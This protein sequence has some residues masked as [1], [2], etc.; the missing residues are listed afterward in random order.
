M[1]DKITTIVK[2]GG[3]EHTMRG[4]ESEEYI[5]KV[6]IFVNRKME[7][8]ERMQPGLSTTQIAVLTAINL[9]DEVIKLKETI[10]AQKLQMANLKESSKHSPAPAIYDVSRKGNR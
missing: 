1:A 4:I 8:I 3:R 2:I 9:G 6:A 5:H 10:E 7:E